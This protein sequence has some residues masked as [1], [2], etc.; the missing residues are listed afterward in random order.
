VVSHPLRP[1]QLVTRG[2]EIRAGLKERQR[3]RKSQQSRF[4][5]E[6]A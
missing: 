3:I 5:W 2:A 1:S 4:P 6:K